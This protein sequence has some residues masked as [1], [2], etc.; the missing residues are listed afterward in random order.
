[1]AKLKEKGKR[2]TEKASILNFQEGYLDFGAEIGEGR[3][4][5]SI[6]LKISARKSP[7]GKGRAAGLELW[8]SYYQAEVLAE[9]LQNFVTSKRCHRKAQT[10]V[11]VSWDG[12]ARWSTFP[13]SV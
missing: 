1:M 4:C 2:G 5:S 12:S 11:T 3:F 8:L 6:K 9:I 13:Y 7:D 10:P